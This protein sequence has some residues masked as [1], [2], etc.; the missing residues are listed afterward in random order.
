MFRTDIKAL[1]SNIDNE[2]LEL[3]GKLNDKLSRRDFVGR[4]LSLKAHSDETVLKFQG[5]WVALTDS[6]GALRQDIDTLEAVHGIYTWNRAWIVPGGHVHKS[7]D[8]H[9]CYPTTQFF[10][11][12]EVSAMTETEIVEAA[13]ERACTVCYPSAPVDVLKRTTKLFTRDEEAANAERQAKLDKRAAKEAAKITVYLAGQEKEETFGTVRSARNEALNSYGWF[14]YSLAFH[15]GGMAP[16]HYADFC[17]LF[18]AIARREGVGWETVKVELLKKGLAKFKREFGKD[19]PAVVELP[20]KLEAY[21]A[22]NKP[23]V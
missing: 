14:L 11:V 5:E 7:R 21:F 19:H 20:A 6:I 16:K 9:S 22:A 1:A 2:I 17:S 4:M 3:A 12:P 13:G 10:L 23:L 18:V 8:C 15:E